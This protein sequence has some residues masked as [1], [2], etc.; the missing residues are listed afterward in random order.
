MSKVAYPPRMWGLKGKPKMG[1]TTFAAANAIPKVGWIDSDGRVDFVRGLAKGEIVKPPS[2]KAN[3]LP[4]HIQDWAEETVLMDEGIQSL[5]VDSVTKI[6]EWQ[7]RRATMHGDLSAGERAAAGLSKNKASD[8]VSKSNAMAI[9]RTLAGLGVS[10]YFVWHTTDGRDHQG[11]KMVGRDMISNVE[12]ERLE[13]SLAAVIE[14]GRDN[15]GYWAKVLQARDLNGIPANVGFTLYDT[16][17]NLWKGGADVLEKLMYTSFSDKQAAVAWLSSETGNPDL[18]EMEAHY[19]HVTAGCKSQ[20]EVNVAVVLSLLSR[21]ETV[22]DRGVSQKKVRGV[23]SPP[24]VTQPDLAIDEDVIYQ[25]KNGPV[26]AT[27]R[28]FDGLLAVIEIEGREYKAAISKLSAVVPPVDPWDEMN[29]EI[30][31]EREQAE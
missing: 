23:N 8:M 15:R 16:P 27:L 5:V 20:M 7:S 24:V 2:R 22:F 9:V 17:G 11:K 29:A 3:I 1:K 30:D 18:A 19:D 31:R 21:G 28:G 14:F 4:L 12:L 26:Q 10:C 25:G 13:A 6:W